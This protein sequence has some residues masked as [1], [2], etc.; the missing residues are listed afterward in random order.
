LEVELLSSNWAIHL[1]ARCK[2]WLQAARRTR[3]SL[4]PDLKQEHRA[5]QTALSLLLNL[6]SQEQRHE[7]EA[8]G[9]FHV[10][11]GNSGDRYRIR[12]DSAVNIDVI[13]ENGTVRY[14]LCARPAGDIPMYDVMAGQLLYLQDS[15]A[16][17]RFL[18]QA[19]RHIPLSF[20]AMERCRER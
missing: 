5:E 7:F 20:A 15:S 2:E 17:K 4:G 1:C 8:Y 12:D 14:R 11:G 6:M 10:I 9:Y 16:E 13:G 19:K 3:E 18:N